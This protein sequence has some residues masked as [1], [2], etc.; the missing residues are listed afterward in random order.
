MARRL[1]LQR[2]MTDESYKRPKAPAPP[3]DESPTLRTSPVRRD[4]AADHAAHYVEPQPL[5]PT[6]DHKTIDMVPVRLAPE[7]NPRNAATRRLASVPRPGWAPGWAPTLALVL[8]AFVLVLV[9]VALGLQ[10][11]GA[12]G[13]PDG[14]ASGA[15]LLK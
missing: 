11:F 15:G 5:R 8:V 9:V 6:S 7:V 3:G 14:A 1:R 10:R 13:T 2:A 12:P 4:L